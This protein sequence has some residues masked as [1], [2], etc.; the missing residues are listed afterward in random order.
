MDHLD[1]DLGNVLHPV[2]HRLRVVLQHLEEDGVD[3]VGVEGLVRGEQ[4]VEHRPQRE[5]VRAGIGFLSPHLLGGHVVRRAHDG[6]GGGHLG[7]AEAGE[8]EVHDLHLPARLD[9]DVPRLQVAVDDLLGVG[10]GEPVADLLHE[11][12]LL[13]EVRDGTRVDDLA[14]IRPLEQLHGHVDTAVLLPQVEDGDDVGMVE[15]RRGLGLTQEALAGIALCGGAARDRLDRDEAVEQ[16]IV[17]L[18]DL[19]HRALADLA[20]DLVF[21]DLLE[22]HRARPAGPGGSAWRL[23]RG[24]IIPSPRVT[25]S[26]VVPVRLT[27]RG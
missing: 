16:G 21:A 12:E 5:D 8:A 11:V 6:A 18:E 23:R 13:A 10:V 17:G 3:R 24:R 22:V 7:G 1:Q 19:A 9:V 15:A 14:E 20:D 2:A 25:G 26:S 27:V 4:L